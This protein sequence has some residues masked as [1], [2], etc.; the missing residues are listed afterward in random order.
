MQGGI[1]GH[2]CTKSFAYFCIICQRLIIY[3]K[4]LTPIILQEGMV[5]Y[6]TVQDIEF[7]L[8]R[9]EAIKKN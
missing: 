4:T 5:G 2:R 7:F 9:C 1:I 8:K 6:E 3:K